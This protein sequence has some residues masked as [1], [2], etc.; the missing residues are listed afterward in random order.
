MVPVVDDEGHPRELP[1]SA[2]NRFGY[3]LEFDGKGRVDDV[4]IDFEAVAEHLYQLSVASKRR[5]RGIVRVI[6]DEQY[7]PMLFSTKRGQEV[8]R[9]VTFMKG[10]PWVRHDEHY[11]VDFAVPCKAMRG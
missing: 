2:L 4:R 7:L 11:H 8:R 3:D 10:K 5:G 1:G 9:L 6:F